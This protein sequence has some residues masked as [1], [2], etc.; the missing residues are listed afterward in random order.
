MEKQS[1]PFAKS[2]TWVGYR[3][4]ETGHQ[5][6][7]FFFRIC[8]RR[9]VE[10]LVTSYAMEGFSFQFTRRKRVKY[11]DRSRPYGDMIVRF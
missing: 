1:Q 9:S 2:F 4:W 6:A 5:N 7:A 3:V 10:K 11:S 8:Y